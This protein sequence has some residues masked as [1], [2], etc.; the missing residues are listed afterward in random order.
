[1]KLSN[2]LTYYRDVEL[3]LT[4]SQW[5]SFIVPI[6]IEV[7]WDT[8]NWKKRSVVGRFYV[9][10]AHLHPEMRKTLEELD[11]FLESLGDYVITTNA[12]NRD[13][14]KLKTW[15]QRTLSWEGNPLVEKLRKER[16]D[17]DIHRVNTEGKTNIEDARHYDAKQLIS[18]QELTDINSAIIYESTRD[19]FMKQFK[20][21]RQKYERA[22]DKG[23]EVYTAILEEVK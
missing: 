22:T 10:E 12:I 21:K 14:A 23:Y 17:L 20:D 4:P 18:K 11:Q 6:G 16:K 8:Y 13:Y 3:R 19:P 7:V 9:S 15:G 2:N 1:M 5:A